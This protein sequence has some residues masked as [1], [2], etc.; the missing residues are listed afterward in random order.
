M[1]FDCSLTPDPGFRKM[2]FQ[3]WVT[4]SPCRRQK[5]DCILELSALMVG[6][7]ETRA[8][9]LRATLRH[10]PAASVRDNKMA[11]VNS[12]AESS[13]LE[14][15]FQSGSPLGRALLRGGEHLHRD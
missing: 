2:R 5:L 12:P 15:I 3:A 14:G 8:K 10:I 9:F 13:L 11:F 1:A 6:L 7:A 4:R